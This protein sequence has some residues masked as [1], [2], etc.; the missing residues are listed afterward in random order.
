MKILYAVLCEQVF[1]RE[2]GRT[3]VRGILHGLSAPGFPAQQN[4]LVLA[5]VLQWEEA[6][7]GS[8]DFRIDLL[9]PTGTPALT[10]TGQ[11]EVPPHTPGSL[12][13][14]TPLVMPLENVVF[15][16]AGEYIFQL[17][18]GGEHYPLAPLVLSEM[19]PRE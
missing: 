5:V 13:R 10:I 9:D 19:P 6:E 1:A 18:L 7:A 15:P 4:R 2:D 14:R 17:H 8:I 11:T 16:V 12:P 3:D